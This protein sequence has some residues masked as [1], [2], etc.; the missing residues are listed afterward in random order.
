MQAQFIAL[1]SISKGTAT[2]T[3]NIFENRFMHVQEIARMGGKISLKGN[4][5]IIEG[6][7]TLVGAP[8]MATD[9]RASASLVLAGLVAE[10]TTEIDRIYH[11]DR[12]YERIEEKLSLLGGDIERIS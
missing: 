10:G 4:T 12:G 3:E 1:N 5:A 6:R 11:I 8:V 2:V 7:K 9:L